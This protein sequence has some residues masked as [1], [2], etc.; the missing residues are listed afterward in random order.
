MV[1]ICLSSGTVLEHSVVRQ[2]ALPSV[3]YAIL[4]FFQSCAETQCQSN[5]VSHSCLG[6]GVTFAVFQQQSCPIN[7]GAMWEEQNG[8]DRHDWN[9]YEQPQKKSTFGFFVCLF[10]RVFYGPIS[11][12]TFDMG[13]ALAQCLPQGCQQPCVCLKTIIMESL[14]I[15]TRPSFSSSFWFSYLYFHGVPCQSVSDS[16]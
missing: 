13:A 1:S 8:T 10:S 9:I 15:W 5:R 16:R 2:E 14:S 7:C 11:P 12:L 6:N 4:L 3:P